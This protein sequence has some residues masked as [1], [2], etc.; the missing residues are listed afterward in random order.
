MNMGNRW[1]KM[2]G[3]V[4]NIRLSETE[5]IRSRAHLREFMMMTPMKRVESA[6][7]KK[8][9]FFAVMHNFLNKKKAMPVFGLVFAM[10]LAGTGVTYA[11]E[12]AAPGDTLYPVKVHVNE[13]IGN[14]FAFSEERKANWEARLAERRL[15]EAEK[16]AAKG[17]LNPEVRQFLEEK[18]MDH[19]NKTGERIGKIGERFGPEMK[20]RLSSRFEASLKAHGR[21]LARMAETTEVTDGEENETEGLADVVEEEADDAEEA[22]ERAEED[23]DTN[24]ARPD[25]E[26]AA[27][28]RL[29][30]TEKKITEVSSFIDKKEGDIG[31]DAAIAAREALAEADDL[32]QQALGLAE[33]GEYGDSF[34]L[35]QQAHRLAN[36]ARVL[37]AAKAKFHIGFSWDDAD[38]DGSET[39]EEDDEV[40]IED[41]EDDEGGEDEDEDEE[42]E[43]S[44]SSE[45]SEKTRGRK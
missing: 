24:I 20:A 43:I 2:M 34:R 23:V 39:D 12:D 5:K 26:R 3:S 37:T 30:A 21:I 41:D 22:R 35:A 45:R 6:K 44:S 10:M 17:E 19:A 42:S 32:M 25:K 38:D 16:L 13:N 29:K 15:E 18:F 40:G 4:R 14:A 27:Q 9:P 1:E 33:E 8:Q 11:A 7:T 28:G 36:H 31:E